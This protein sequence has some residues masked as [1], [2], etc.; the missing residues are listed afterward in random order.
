MIF[1]YLH[2]DICYDPSLKPSRRD[3]FNEGSQHIISE[4]SLNHSC[5]PFFSGALIFNCYSCCIPK[6]GNSDRFPLQ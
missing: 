1:I 2:K 4:L 5:Y 6:G 3:G